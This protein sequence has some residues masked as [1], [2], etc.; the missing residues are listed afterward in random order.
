MYV[1]SEIRFQNFTSWVR[2]PIAKQILLAQQEINCLRISE[3]V[4]IS[5]PFELKAAQIIQ[6]YTAMHVN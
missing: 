2:R 1:N 4:L 6:Y 5:T 3:P